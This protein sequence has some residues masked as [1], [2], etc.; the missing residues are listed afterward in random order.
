MSIFLSFRKDRVQ[1]GAVLLA[2][3]N[4]MSLLAYERFL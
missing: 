3:I 1:A 2:G 4:F